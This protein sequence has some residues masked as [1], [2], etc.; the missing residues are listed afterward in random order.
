LSTDF[1]LGIAVVIATFA[2]PV[3]AVFVKA[4]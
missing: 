3:F 4:H 2:G 1:V